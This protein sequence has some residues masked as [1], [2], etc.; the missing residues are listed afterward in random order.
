MFVKTIQS[1]KLLME[2]YQVKHFITA[3][4][5]AMRDAANSRQIISR[6][7]GETGIDIK[8]ISGEE[9]AADIEPTRGNEA[10][11]RLAL[12]ERCVEV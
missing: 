7:K 2:V 3:A 5:S 8:V 12:I 11:A 4:T 1:Y 9:E 6:S 10:R